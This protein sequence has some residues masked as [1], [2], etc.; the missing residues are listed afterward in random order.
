MRTRLY[1]LEAA[2]F[3]LAFLSFPIHFGRRRRQLHRKNHTKYLPATA[4]NAKE[5]QRQRATAAA[6]AVATPTIRKRNSHT[7]SAKH[8]T[9]T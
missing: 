7:L 9:A 3:L 4:N 8:Q 5:K 2:S 1:R 6:V